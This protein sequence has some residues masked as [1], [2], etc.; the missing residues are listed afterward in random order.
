ARI[1][2]KRVRL[3]IADGQTMVIDKVARQSASIPS[4]TKGDIKRN[5][6]HGI[7]VTLRVINLDRSLQF[8]Q[9]VLGL[10]IESQNS[11]SARFSNGLRIVMIPHRDTGNE[12]DS[13]NVLISIPVRD[14]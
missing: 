8:Y 13:R 6:M 3:R 12:Y 5:G 4:N 9:E 14:L 1:T 2:V 7:G 11:D 10:F